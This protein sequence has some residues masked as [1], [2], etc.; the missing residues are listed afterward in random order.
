MTG[1]RSSRD[2]I[3]DQ[4]EKF[5]SDTQ[6]A[7]AANC[8]HIPRP[9]D[10]TTV[11]GI[12]SLSPLIR[13]PASNISQITQAIVRA[14]HTY[15][16]S[17]LLTHTAPRPFP[18]P[19]AAASTRPAMPPP[20]PL[21]RSAPPQAV[22]PAPHTETSAESP[23][24]RR[25]SRLPPPSLLLVERRGARDRPAA[26]RRRLAGAVRKLELLASL[27][28]VIGLELLWSPPG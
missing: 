18:C 27:W 9:T 17:L 12:P 28:V 20:S 21:P 7:T 24:R 5:A 2:W 6:V 10:G 26:A 8:T 23:G 13:P 16:L 11:R 25:A 3:L 22:S 1:A 4:N 15:I 14:T 19:S